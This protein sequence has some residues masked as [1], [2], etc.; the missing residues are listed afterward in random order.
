MSGKTLSTFKLTTTILLTVI[1]LAGCG[2]EKEKAP[3]IVWP[4]PPDE[5]KIR[6][7]RDFFGPISF[8][9]SSVITDI[10]LG[11]TP[12]ASFLKPS[13]VYV[14]EDFNIIVTDT[15]RGNVFVMNER[16][17]KT[18]QLTKGR[19]GSFFKPVGVSGT[20]SGLTFVT[21]TTSD[22]ISVF[23]EKDKY[24]RNIGEDLD[25]KQPT[26]TAVDNV[27][28]RLYVT[29]THNHHIKVFNS[30]TLEYIKNIGK[31][32]TLKGDFNFPTSL[33]INSKGDLH[34]VDTM[35]GRV[36]IF[37]KD[38]KFLRTFGQLGDAVGMFARPRGIAIDSDDH[39]YVVDGAFNNVQI[40]NTEGQ[41]LLYF[42]GFGSGPGQ[43]VLPAGIAI[44]SEDYI[45][46]I[47][48][49]NARLNKYQYLGDDSADTEEATTGN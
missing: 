17:E 46:V 9:K 14:D 36:Q 15:A 29:D 10:A 1:L 28:G 48:S 13:A 43:M 25:I 16:T 34:V 8:E 24:V 12:G 3:D 27:N 38:G 4:K 20:S 32:G 37:D 35:N 39:I 7:I 45:Y 21:D 47:D 23:D 22:E 19:R 18:H 5:P 2:P 49:W 31:R 41:L 33:A 42:G 26:G 6:F 30:E 44:D 11:A 40:F